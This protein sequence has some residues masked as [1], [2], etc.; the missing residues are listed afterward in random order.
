MRKLLVILSLL[1]AASM[2][3]SA[4]GPATTQAPSGGA[5]APGEP[6]TAGAMKSKDPTTWVNVSFGEPDLLDPALDYETA[7]SE[8]IQNVYEGLVFFKGESASEVE[9]MLAESYTV[10]DDGMTYTFA[11]RKGVK[12]HNGADLDVNDVVYSFVR[13]MMQGGY[14]S[15]EFLLVEPFFG[16]GVSDVGEL[17]GDGSAAGDPDAMKLEDPAAMAQICED[18]YAK[19]AVDEAAN[20]VT[21]TLATP[22][23]PFLPTIAQTWGSILDKDWAIENGA[24][25]G[26]CD[27]WQ[28]WYAIL[29]E[30]DTLGEI[31][32]GTGPFMLDHWTKGEEIALARNDNY[33]REPAKLQKV[34]I[35][36]WR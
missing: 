35:R 19:F 5:Q 29:A 13:G 2:A 15:P 30:N 31:A 17:V 25:D 36:S 22:W 27:T 6:S 28:N 32:N 24:W 34:I 1:V 9:P 23:G 11:L 33:W 16:V 18:T 14:D 21:M 20:T 10:S 7:G 12:F 8:I 3:L 26:S 4:C